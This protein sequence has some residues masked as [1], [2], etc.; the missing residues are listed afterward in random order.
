MPTRD[1]VLATLLS[2]WPAPPWARHD[3]EVVAA[4]ARV[5][6]VTPA[7]TLTRC[8]IVLDWMIHVY[9]PRWLV[10]A[11]LPGDA[12]VLRYRP[13][14]RSETASLTQEV[15]ASIQRH[16]TAARTSFRRMRRLDPVAAAELTREAVLATGGEACVEAIDSVDLPLTKDVIFGLAVD[17]LQ[18]A[19][20]A[21]KVALLYGVQAE[22][23]PEVVL[24][25]VEEALAR[26]VVALARH[27]IVVKQPISAYRRIGLGR[28]VR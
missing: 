8:W 7:L 19:G 3:V 1:P 14:M 6:M 24:R 17:V 12:D 10:A 28:R 16:V 2:H 20:N 11:G 18:L 13:G 9:A 4:Q 25:P 21:A 23:E 15:V 5:A 22:R 26:E 27:L